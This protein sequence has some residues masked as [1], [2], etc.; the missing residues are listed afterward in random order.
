MRKFIFLIFAVFLQTNLV[1]GA[2]FTV[3]NSLDNGSGSLRSALQSAIYTPA[4]PHQIVFNIP[5]S[6]NGYNATKGTW[7]I[8][9]T[10]PLPYITSGQIKIDATTQTTY[11]G[12]TNINGPEIELDGAYNVDYAFHIFNAANVEVRG[13][14]IKRFIYGIQISGSS[15]VHNII[16]GNYIGVNHNA[17]DTIGCYIGIE[18]LSLASENL[19][20][21]PQIQDRNIVSGN[22][23]IGIRL[24]HSSNNTIINNYVG[25]DRTG[26]IAL[27]NYDGISLEAL[28]Q[29]N[30]I[31]GLT[32]Q[33]RNVVSGNI[34]YGIPLIGLHTRYNK[35]IGNY[36]GTNASGTAPVPNTYGVLFDDGSRYNQVGGYQTGESN[37]ISGNSGYGVFIYNYGTMENY[38]V[39]NLIGTDYTGTQAVPNANGIVI[40]GIAT[41][42]LIDK[43]IISGNI[44]QGI[45]I[46]ISGSNGHHIT[47]NKIGTDISGLY[48]LGNGEDGI[49]IAEGAQLNII[50]VAPDSGNIIAYNG[51]CGVTIMT[52]NDIKNRISGNSIY[53][54][55]VQGIDLYPPG[56]NSNDAGDTDS[57]PNNLQNYPVLLS[58]V[59]NQTTGETTL[60]GSIDTQ[61]PD[62]CVIEFFLS[63]DDNLGYGQGKVF[64]GYASPLAN[65]NFS[66]IFNMPLSLNK[67]C[68]TTTDKEGNTSEFSQN[69]LLP[70]PAG[71]NTNNN[72]KNELNIFPMPATDVLFIERP[73]DTFTKLYL[74]NIQGE[75]IQY[76]LLSNK[77]HSIDVSFLASGTY[78]IEIA[79]ESEM[80]KSNLVIV[81]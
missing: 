5:T 15:A 16:A 48:P 74:Y 32:P 14:V 35:I 71:I 46:H 6:D 11:A 47:R 70:P 76:H 81:R 38:V 41:N 77:I 52:L 19:I 25:L 39:G 53:A 68:A 30:I 50:G 75:L 29:N 61:N 8:N 65:G 2:V 36:I 4:P 59:Y 34:A 17:S 72:A 67:L 40:D 37:L 13:F 66:H 27:P 21:G 57:G 23:H 62:S 78:I 56:P 79:S 24:L 18:I 7:T 12:N 22:Q 26:E 43:N 60:N 44:Q 31:G 73:D 80:Y 1:I 33:E 42:H 20:G 3:T 49:R 69:L 54:N 58:A 64:I 55:A 51:N 28:T 45:A 9:L 63:D 10:R